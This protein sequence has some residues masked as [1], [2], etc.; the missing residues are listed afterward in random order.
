MEK[1]NELQIPWLERIDKPEEEKPEMERIDY[2][3]MLEELEYK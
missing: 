3:T 1:E 2:M